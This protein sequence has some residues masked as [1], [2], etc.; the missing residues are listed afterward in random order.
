M[1][2]VFCVFA[3]HPAR[4][5]HIPF[6]ITADIPNAETREA[7]EEVQRMK[8]DPTLGKTYTDMDRMFQDLLSDA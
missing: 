5:E 3:V 2:S 6:E 1:N 4:E 7:I 8:A